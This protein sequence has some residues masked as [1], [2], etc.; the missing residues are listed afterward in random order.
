MG[1]LPMPRVPR[2]QG[3]QT[4]IDKLS[5]YFQDLNQYVVKDDNIDWNYIRSEKFQTRSPALIITYATYQMNS[6][7]IIKRRFLFSYI[8]LAECENQAEINADKSLQHL[9]RKYN[10][11]EIESLMAK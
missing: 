5:R 11:E 8:M 3:F 7:E 9:Q 10:E 6:S 1:C 2:V 4:D